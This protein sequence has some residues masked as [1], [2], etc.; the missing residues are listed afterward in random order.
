MSARVLVVEDEHAIRL[1]LK[2]LLTRDPTP[3]IS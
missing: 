3:S 1:A 2:G